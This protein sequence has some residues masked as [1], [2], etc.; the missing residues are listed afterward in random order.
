MFGKKKAVIPIS[1]ILMRMNAE[2]SNPCKVSDYEL[3]FFINL[4]RAI[5][6]A[7]LSV[8][9]FYT[10]RMGSEAIRLF[11]RPRTII[12]MVNLREKIGSIQYYV[13]SLGT[14]DM[15]DA[16]IEAIIAVIPYWIDYTKKCA[17]TRKAALSV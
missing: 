13:D 10:K 12:G 9:N 6:E 4:E 1:Q 16:P 5:V 11:Y 8:S 14:H 17:K 2:E 7:G 3:R 15:K